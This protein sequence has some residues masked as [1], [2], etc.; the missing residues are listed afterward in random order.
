MFDGDE[1]PPAPPAI[2][3]DRSGPKI[4][5][6]DFEIEG[7]SPVYDMTE[8]PFWLTLMQDAGLKTGDGVMSNQ[9]Q[10][11]VDRVL[12]EVDQALQTFTAG[13][14]LR[15]NV[16]TDPEGNITVPG[17][18]ILTSVGLGLEPVDALAEFY[19]VPRFENAPPPAALN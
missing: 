19:R 17:G 7:P 4:E 11:A 16:Y 10:Q 15:V 3:P 9:V 12:P 14:L 5:L 13:S 18:E 8:I 2:R 6:P 1:V